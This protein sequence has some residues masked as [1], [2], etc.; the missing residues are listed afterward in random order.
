LKVEHNNGCNSTVV[1]NADIDAGDMLDA[2]QRRGVLG[3]NLG[4]ELFLDGPCLCGGDIPGVMGLCIHDANRM[5]M[6]IEYQIAKPQAA[7]RLAGTN[8]KMTR[9]VWRLAGSLIG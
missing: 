5:A 8:K 1:A 6:C 7:N 4:A 3:E 2:S 9:Q